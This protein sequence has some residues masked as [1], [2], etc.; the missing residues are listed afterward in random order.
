MATEYKSEV[1]TDLSRGDCRGTVV[2]K[3]EQ[4]MDSI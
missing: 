1:R 2:R 4:Y 3:R